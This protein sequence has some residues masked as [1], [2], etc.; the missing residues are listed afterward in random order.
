MVNDVNRRNERGRNERKCFEKMIIIRILK[1]LEIIVVLFAAVS[2]A[3]IARVL[4]WVL[5]TWK[6]LSMEEL[7]YQLKA[8]IQG[9]N[10][11]M[12]KDCVKFCLPVMVIILAVVILLMVKMRGKVKYHRLMG[13]IFLLSVMV[14]FGFCGYAWKRLEIGEYLKNQGTYST[15]LDEHYV[16]PNTVKLTFPEKK[17]NLIYIYLESMEMTYADKKTGGGFERNCIPELAK[18]AQENEDFSGS[19]EKLNGANVLY[20]TTWTIAAMF[21]QSSGLPLAIPIEGSAMETQEDFFPQM[22]ALGDILEEQGYKN[23]LLLGSPAIFGGRKQFFETHGNYVI[24]DHNYMAD[25][26]KLPEDYYVWWGYEDKKLFEFA[27]E[28]LQELSSQD[29]PFNLTLLTVDTHFEDG[30]DCEDCRNLF[31]G[32]QYA[33]VMACSSR[34]IAEFLEWVQHQDFYADTTVVLAGDHLTMDSDFCDAVSEDYQRK[35]YTAYINSAAEAVDTG[36][37]REYTTFDHF[38]TTLA[39]LG[40]QIDGNRLGLGT[41]LFSGEQTLLEEY[42]MKTM[43]SELRRKSKMMEELTAG[44]DMEKASVPR[45]VL[46]QPTAD[47]R[48]EEYDPTAE[49][50]RVLIEHPDNPAGAVSAV[51]LTVWTEKDRSDAKCMEAELYQ[52]D[53]YRADINP[54]EFGGKSGAYH[55]EIYIW[56][57][58]GNH[59]L[60]EE[61]SGTVPD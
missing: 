59:K 9:T 49:I 29:Q 4:R 53:S 47:I 60:V 30:Y 19:E 8:P 26:G 2:A 7:V 11:S 17:R 45:E 35:A 55:I 14:I 3:L 20:N 22:T 57:T 37:P 61:V 34:Q 46:Y 43:N 25:T 18:I 39:S 28:E 31:E 58:K 32:N 24:K 56:D 50:L 21:A 10:V 16:K 6:H 33:N 52:E 5:K 41:N 48:V 44:I 51:D 38:P 13:G 12:I 54:A 40:V 15:F 1:S 36:K 27:K 23:T 42:G